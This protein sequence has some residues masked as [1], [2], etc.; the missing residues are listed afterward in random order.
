MAMCYSGT[1]GM[2]SAPQGGCSSISE[3]V[4]G[5]P[6]SSNLYNMGYYNTGIYNMQGYYGYNPVT[7]KAVKWCVYDSYDSWG[8]KYLCACLVVDPPM[9]YNECFT[10]TLYADTSVSYSDGYGSWSC[11]FTGDWSFYVA[12]DSYNRW[13]SAQCDMCITPYSCTTAMVS[14]NSSYNYQETMATMSIN[15]VYNSVGDFCIDWSCSS[16]YVRG[17]YY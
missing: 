1:L 6:Q 14:I 16:I 9:D 13:N 10:M 5:Y 3:A 17:G 4:Y 15:D 2:I 8:Y 11:A 12:S 7:T